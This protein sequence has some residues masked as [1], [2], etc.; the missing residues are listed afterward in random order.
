MTDFEPAIKLKKQKTSNELE[1]ENNV[2]FI[3]THDTLNKNIKILIFVF[4]NRK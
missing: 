4:N 3:K 2:R 1:Q